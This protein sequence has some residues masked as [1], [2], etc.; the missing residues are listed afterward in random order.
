[1]KSQ[2]KSEKEAMIILRDIT[3]GFTLTYKN[4]KDN[5]A[6]EEPPLSKLGIKW[7]QNIIRVN[8]QKETR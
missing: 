4:I 8:R 3:R 1:M 6:L 2:T 5:S 7:I